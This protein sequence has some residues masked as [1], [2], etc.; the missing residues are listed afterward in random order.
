MRFSIDG[1]EAKTRQEFIEFFLEVQNDYANNAEEEWKDSDY[2][3]KLK[4]QRM[5][6]QDLINEYESLTSC[7]VKLI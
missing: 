5:S 3:W 2:L 4:M 1:D 7:S 6:D